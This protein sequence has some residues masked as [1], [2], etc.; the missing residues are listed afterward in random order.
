MA[1]IAF[2]IILS[3]LTSHTTPPTT[4]SRYPSPNPPSAIAPRRPGLENRA[5][6]RCHHSCIPHGDLQGV[7]E[8]HLLHL[9]DKPPLRRQLTV[10]IAQ[11]PPAIRIYARA[12]LWR[13]V[14]ASTLSLSSSPVVL[15]AWRVFSSPSQPLKGRARVGGSAQVL[16][17]EAAPTPL[18]VPPRNPPAS[19]TA[20][21]GP[22]SPRRLAFLAYQDPRTNARTALPAGLLSYAVLRITTFTSRQDP[23][24]TPPR[25]LRVPDAADVAMA[26]PSRC[27]FAITPNLLPCARSPALLQ[28]SPI[29]SIRPTPYRRGIV[30]RFLLHAFALRAAYPPTAAGPRWP[31]DTTWRPCCSSSSS[32]RSVRGSPRSA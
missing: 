4:S 12:P 25:S 18:P 2:Q 6:R 29:A 32:S 14:E 7:E 10:A 15:R 5:S 28:P 21:L 30:A 26:A 9:L 1:L 22:S 24:R 17:L 11:S 27:V 16:F 20:I 8:A 3:S 19:H 13:Y 31:Q 23:L